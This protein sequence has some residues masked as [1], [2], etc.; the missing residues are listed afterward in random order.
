MVAEQAF[1]LRMV[2]TQLLISI[3]LSKPLNPFVPIALNGPDVHSAAQATNL[4]V[5]LDP[6]FAIPCLTYQ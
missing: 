2:K 6:C 3:L 5:I 4:G 1:Q